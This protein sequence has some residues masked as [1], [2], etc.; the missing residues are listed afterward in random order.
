MS[1]KYRISRDCT[2]WAVGKEW[3]FSRFTRRVWEAFAA[4]GRTLVPN[5][6]REL[7]G[8]IREITLQDAET[9]REV[10]AADVKEIDKAKAEG[11][12]PVIVG[13]KFRG[14]ADWLADKALEKATSYLSAQSKELSGLLSSHEG[15]AYLF[16]L[17][18]KPR[19]PDIT[20]DEAYDVF[21]DL[22]M[23]GGADGRQTVERII[24]TCNGTAPEPEKNG[25]PP[26]A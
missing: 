14:M 3:T 4:H 13:D 22:E 1:H 9:L 20:E 24:R 23:N 2:E 25:S 18:L 10:L 19:H 8:V 5:P 16:W 12:T 6:L 21:V 11:R 15:S 7:K 26:A 17:L